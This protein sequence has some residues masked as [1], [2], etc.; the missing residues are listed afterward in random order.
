MQEIDIVNV[1][2]D[3]DELLT[4][5]NN[6]FIKKFDWFKDNYR[7]NVL[8]VYS[9]YLMLCACEYIGN[10]E[11]KRDESLYMVIPYEYLIKPDLEDSIIE[12]LNVEEYRGSYQ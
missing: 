7:A 3:Y 11:D 8:G 2:G 1:I 12:D 9:D 5:A 6:I 10:D 4:Q